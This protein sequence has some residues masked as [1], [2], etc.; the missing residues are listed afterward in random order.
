MKVKRVF[1]LLV[2]CLIG[3]V[4]LLLCYRGGLHAFR[5]GSP[6]FRDYPYRRCADN[7]HRLGMAIRSYHQAIG[8]FP[9]RV[10]LS[11]S[12]LPMHSWRFRLL[13]YTDYN[14]DL[15][16]Y[17]SDEPWDS[18]GNRKLGHFG[19][20][21]YQCPDDSSRTAVKGCTSYFYLTDYC[22]ENRVVLVECHGAGIEWTEPV[23]LDINAL[24]VLLNKSLATAGEHEP[25]CLAVISRECRV[26]RLYSTNVEDYISEIERT[27]RHT[28]GP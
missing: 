6:Y 18:P 26:V 22:D 8:E 20:P 28:A 2:I 16:E 25:G 12:G 3:F 27:V 11:S 10:V 19:V 24:R 4:S 1:S 14:Y 23:D 9:P 7:I 21:V 15:S 13:P 17:D 5:S